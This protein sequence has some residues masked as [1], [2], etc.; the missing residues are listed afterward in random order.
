MFNTT[1]IVHL[2]A[3]PTAAKPT[4]AKIREDWKRK[5]YFSYF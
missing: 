2:P 1:Y 5:Y 3:N 4:P